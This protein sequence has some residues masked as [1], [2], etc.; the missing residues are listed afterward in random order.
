M[1]TRGRMS[2]HKQLETILK[3]IRNQLLATHK[4]VEGRQS[5][6]KV[7][8]NLATH[9][10]VDAISKHNKTVKAQFMSFNC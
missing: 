4:H 7:E 2:T 9:K 8:T 5:T 6:V 1:N 3:Q 10:Q